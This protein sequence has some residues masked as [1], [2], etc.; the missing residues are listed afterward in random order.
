[1]KKSSNVMNRK[2]L[3]PLI[4]ALLIIIQSIH[5]QVYT[6][7]DFQW[8]YH[9]AGN[10]ASE[11]IQIVD[12]TGP[13][14]NVIIPDT[15]NDGQHAIPVTAIAGKNKPV[16]EGSS[17][18]QVTLGA[19]VTYLG[20]GTF[21]YCD[22]LTTVMLG[23]KVSTIGDS[24][25]YDCPSLTTISIPASVTNIGNYVFDW[26]TSLTNIAVE[27]N[28]SNY[29]S[30]GGV[31]FDKSKTALFRYPLALKN[32]YLIP[33]SVTN[34]S[35]HAF[36]GSQLSSVMM[37]SNIATIAPG[38][39]ANC[40]RMTDI[41]VN[42]DNKNFESIY[43][44]PSQGVG[45]N[46]LFDKSG[47]TLLQVPAGLTNNYNI[48][49]SVINI[50]DCAFWGSKIQSIQMSHANI[51]SIGTAAFH[52]C[53]NLTRI[54]IPNG[55][56][57]ISPYLCEYCNHLMYIGLPESITSIGE[58][59]FAE[60]PNLDSF[61][62]IPS[63]VVNLGTGAFKS[64][65]NLTSIY[66]EGDAPTV[67]WG[68]GANDYSVFDS[69]AT[70]AEPGK[71]V[72][73]T[74]GE[75]EAGGHVYYGTGTWGWGSTF[76]GLPT[77]FYVNDDSD[78][79][80]V[81]LPDGTIEII[82][83][84]GASLSVFIPG[85]IG[86]TLVTSI[87]DNAFQGKPIIFV[88]IPD[89]VTKIGN[90]AFS[91]CTAL[92]V[93]R[94]GSGNSHVITI[95]NSAFANCTSLPYMNIPNSALILGTYCFNNCLSLTNLWLGSGLTAFSPDNAFTNCINLASISI[96]PNNAHW[97]SSGGVVF[98]KSMGRLQICPPGYPGSYNIPNSVI[99]VE[100][101]AFQNC[102]KLN[103]VTIPGSVT[104]I[105]AAAFQHCS[106]LTNVSVPGGVAYL[107]DFAF[108]QCSSLTS[109]VISSS[110][111][112]G[113]SCFQDC[114]GL[115]N[116]LL[117]NSINHIGTN[118]FKGCVG[119]TGLTIPESVLNI[120]TSAFM[121]CA[122]L[123]SL[124]LGIN[125]A[126]IGPQAFYG[127]ISLTN[128]DIPAGVTNLGN[129][130]F[131]H[132]SQLTEAV[133]EGNAPLVNGGDGSSDLTVFSGEIG[134]VFYEANTTG[135]QATFGGWPTELSSP[136]S[137]F[138]YIQLN[139]VAT[140]T[141]IYVSN[142]FVVIP[143][144]INGNLVT[145]L[146]SA[147]LAGAPSV[148]S[149]L[150]PG[151][152]TTISTGAFLGATSLT[153]ISVDATNPTY[154][155]IGG[156][157][158][159]KNLTTLVTYPARL[160][161]SYVISNGVASIAPFAFA[162][163]SGLN[164]ITIPA[165]AT[166]IGSGAFEYCSGLAHVTIPDAITRLGSAA[167]SYCSNLTDVTLGSGVTDIGGSAFDSCY[168]LKGINIPNAATNIGPS[169][170][171]YCYA[172]K[173]LTIPTGVQS[174]G[175]LAFSSCLNLN[176]LLFL[177]NAPAGL[178]GQSIFQGTPPAGLKA[179]YLDG[180]SGWNGL[181]SLD[182]GSPLVK[183]CN[184]ATASSGP[185]TASL[186]GKTVAGGYYAAGDT[187]V[188][189]ATPNPGYAFV[190]WTVNGN[191]VSGLSSYPITVQ[192]N[193]TLVANF[194][195]ASNFAGDPASYNF[196][197]DS[198][199][200]V[201]SIMG[202][203]GS[204]NVLYLPAMVTNGGATYTV[205]SLNALMGP[206]TWNIKN[207]IVPDT[208]T[209][210]SG[211][212]FMNL[213][214]LTNVTLGRGIA[215]FNSSALNTANNLQSINVDA[216]NPNYA[217][218]DGILYDK[219]LT[220]L[221]RCPPLGNTDN[222]VIPGS[223]ARIADSAF[224]NCHLT[225]VT[226]PASVTN[227]G[228]YAFSGSGLTSAVISAAR[229]G[230]YAFNGC[231][232]T[233]L[234]L[235]SGVTS[236]GTNA[237]YYCTSLPSLVLP[238]SVTSIG[239]AAFYGSGI[240]N[241]VIGRGLGN[242]GYNV[243]SVCVNLTS[244][245]IPNTLTNIGNGAFSDCSHLGRIVIPASVTSLD[246]GA[247]FYDSALKTVWFYG[248]K[249]TIGPSGLYFN[250]PN[251]TFPGGSDGLTVYYLPGTTGWAGYTQ[252]DNG[253]PVVCWNLQTGATGN[254]GKPPGVRPDGSGHQRFGFDIVGPTNATVVVESCTSLGNPVWV[255]ISTNQLTGGTSY[256][257]D[258]QWTNYGKG[259]YHFRTP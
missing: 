189:V 242:L 257:S 131:A 200:F 67:N 236:I 17:V 245:T 169:A 249:P 145:S 70:I 154:S 32:G 234:T 231:P 123:S 76:G 13:G 136:F 140:I 3:P 30:A 79:I 248:N 40:T 103:G 226:V 118:A 148:H 230:D 152:V 235:G 7:G 227:V 117:G 63:S 247:F 69:S 98:D 21:G 133:F 190:N 84:I 14:G 16:F 57:S 132:C 225:G 83:Y 139:G 151:T 194:T 212:A 53:P 183:L 38:A 55:V 128:V 219:T 195:V 104:R 26:C 101:G 147:L 100:P 170:F 218:L 78:F 207:V 250:V 164:G 87:G 86:G 232:L 24:A 47:T 22:N 73:A 153:N 259:F 197:Y 244:V 74:P 120:D 208:I 198:Q 107:G 8:M 126:Y 46:W 50:G 209:N 165:S 75:P 113:N 214:A 160:S 94:M 119:L 127:C 213:G 112:L 59:A 37:G 62:V 223:V 196:M 77:G 39:L 138:N 82:N 99:T 180:T 182:N 233:S 162:Y 4:F 204:T 211:G 130:A 135:W 52:S 97:T 51:S 176:S 43:I 27:A 191:M 48:P 91:G 36:F 168:H 12:Y 238:D 5:A 237:F 35:V 174:L 33:N 88:T 105:G 255:P 210:I 203:L 179:Y 221:V 111:A 220:Q 15:I 134:S 184:L 205:T 253:A 121:G 256:F 28:N 215:T 49:Q 243:F 23:A 41:G 161:G 71:N 229:I 192:S 141:G 193:E 254:S 45:G 29:S 19:N 65:N 6:N 216:G 181:S 81:T 187:C 72:Y 124:A 239:D 222:Y 31:L 93:L 172:L 10:G 129:S 157:L 159:D 95:G 258:L 2:M 9:T 60:C 167:F 224:Q 199:N 56:T 252:A 110:G 18:T 178:T 188:A 102:L 137:G 150:I 163:C 90:Q 206:S 42:N 20:D 106:G 173:S 80:T 115:T 158:Y 125:L 58:Y 202:Y 217:S 68:P 1:M 108:Q 175:D 166:N 44:L 228:N 149:L 171:A 156:V 246:N 143:R 114:S 251:A 92:K 64:A 201:A 61:I 146:G 122:G 186:S 54:D 11:G 241:V 96:D 177:G 25:F 34:I 142:P 155:S 144:L 240:T 185:G 85:Y 116:L 66:F 109:A 89:S